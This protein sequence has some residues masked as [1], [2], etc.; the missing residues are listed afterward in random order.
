MIY[1]FHSDRWFARILGKFGQLL[2]LN[3]LLLLSSIPIVTIGAAQTAGFHVLIQLIQGKEVAIVPSFFHVFRQSF[4]KSNLV[5]IGL[6]LFVWLLGVNWLYYI[7]MDQLF[8]GWIIGLSISTLICAHLFQCTFFSFARYNNR[9]RL[10]L[11]ND[12]KLL[13]MHPFRSILLHSVTLLP[14]LL[15]LLSP[16]LFVF[17]LYSACFFGI[18]GWMYVR[19]GL[20]LA[21]F[22]KYEKVE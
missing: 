11:I 1:F 19:C 12:I 10:I 6:V 17:G 14:L 4:V 20:L 7:Q 18:S 9:L 22:R 16:N 5:W 3:A 21:F 13:I 2:I 15:M 8:N